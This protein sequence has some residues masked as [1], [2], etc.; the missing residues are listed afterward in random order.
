MKNN[1]D[2]IS[3]GKG[4]PIIFLHGLGG[5]GKQ[6]QKLLTHDLPEQMIFPEMPGHG[7]NNQVPESGFSFDSY[8]EEVK[9]LMDEKPDQ[10]YILAGISMGAGIAMRLALKYPERISKAVLLRPAW[11]NDPF[12][13]NLDLLYRLGIKWKAGT[14]EE[15]RQWLLADSK[16]ISIRNESAACAGSVES[17]LSRPDP[18]LAARTLT[19]L[20]SDAPVHKIQD[21]KSIDVPILIIA[22]DG[23]PLHPLHFARQLHEWLPNS[24]FS[25]IASRYDYP[26]RHKEELTLLLKEFIL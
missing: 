20:C 18:A 23:D 26:D 8:A 16:Y 17:Q 9:Y 14:T 22:T 12:P 6:W 13:A 1:R 24:R 15:A 2:L 10:R 7:N 21:I 11:L 3:K 19:D 25:Q 4:D 5:D